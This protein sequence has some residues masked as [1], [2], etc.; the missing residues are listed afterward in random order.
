MFTDAAAAAAAAAAA[1]LLLPM[2]RAHVKM[3]E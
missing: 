1:C 2:L 3:C